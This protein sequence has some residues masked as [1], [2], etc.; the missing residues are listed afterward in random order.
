MGQLGTKGAH[1]FHVRSDKVTRLVF[2]FDRERAFADLGLAPEFD[3]SVMQRWEGNTLRR[4]DASR[5]G[6]VQRSAASRRKE[7]PVSAMRM[8]PAVNEQQ[9]PAGRLRDARL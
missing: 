1:L 6:T 4:S 7:G 9:A 3:R 8:M 5:R 2:Y